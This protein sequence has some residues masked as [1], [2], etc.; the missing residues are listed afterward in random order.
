MASTFTKSIKRTRNDNLDSD[1]E[2]ELYVTSDTWPRFIVMT[3][4]SEE[5]PLSKLSPFAVQKGFQ[6]IA[7]TLKSTKRLRDGSFLVECSRR[8]QAEN[9]LKTTTFVDRP[10]HVSMHKTLNSSRGVI[11]CREL[12][13][14]S[15]AEIGEE[16]K[17]QG[18]VEVHRVTVKKE[19]KVIPTNTL[20]L[21]FNR[22]DM[23]KELRVGYLKVKVDLFIP[24]P[25]RCFNCNKFGHTS[26]R[27]K[28]AAKCQRCGKDKHEEQCEG[29][30]IC[31]NCS[32]PHAASAKDCPVWKKEKEIQRIRVEKRISFPEARQLVEATSPS[33]GFTSN[34]SFADV[35]N[36][37]RSVKS[38]VCQTDLTWV[39][40]D[41]PVQTVRSVS[42]VS[43]GPG[44]V[45][46]GTQASSGKSGPVSTDAR[47]LRE[48]ALQ[49]D[50]SS[51]SP[52][53][54]PS[55]SPKH[56]TLTPGAGSRSSSEPRVPTNGARSRT[57]GTRRKALATKVKVAGA[58]VHA[59]DL[60]KSAASRHS[61]K[62]TNPKD[63]GGGN[64]PPKGQDDPLKTFNRFGS[65]EEDA[66][67]EVEASQTSLPSSLSGST[68]SLK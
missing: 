67:M 52:G 18:V 43:G 66:G 42:L 31:S 16:L 26:Q 17:S 36:K 47:A 24:N 3:S 7:G 20:F 6:A 21:T 44:S 39:S 19:G 59:A 22:P 15:E 10:V 13:L 45:S 32:G 14:L 46:I 54:G 65:L 63:K 28:T 41:T 55:T 37:K 8:A 23:P 61:K 49:A 62:S 68:S 4:A 33:T 60:L 11:R 25:L 40:S 64:R 1:S 34:L 50:K 57:T 2:N 53:A 30:Q 38:V 58:W 35:L 5:K 27:C 29:P 51:G 48:S 9:L 56:Q 12:S